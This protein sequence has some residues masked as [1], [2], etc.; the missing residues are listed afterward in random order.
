MEMLA[1]SMRWNV[2]HTL[3]RD[4]VRVRSAYDGPADTVE[5]YLSDALGVD[6]RVS[7]H[8]GPARANRKPVLSLLSISGEL[9]GFAKIGINDLTRRL[10]RAEQDSLTLLAGTEWTHT[11][12]PTLLHAGH[13]REFPIVVMSALPVER[14]R[15][16]VSSTRLAE[17]MLEVAAAGGI[18]DHRLADSPYWSSLRARLEELPPGQDADGV[19]DAAAVLADRGGSAVLRMGSWHG[20][21]TPWNM[22]SVTEAIL[23]W[24]WERF[25]GP[26][27]LGFD[28]V[29]YRLQQDVIRAGND[30]RTAVTEC[31]DGA[32]ALLAPFG[33]GAFEAELTV[34]LYLVDLAARYLKDGQAEA[35]ARLGVIGEWLLPELHTR[36]AAL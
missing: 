26:V 18:D 27:P 11:Q 19:H 8:I 1:S 28:A 20:D 32:P 16:P 36:V 13:W 35:G 33:I 17:S 21:W 22:A 30:P 7:L 31:V 3:M 4:R 12:V 14:R 15:I 10:V 5:T 25:T 24:D 2:G 23:L 9:L 29:H 34:L 6:L